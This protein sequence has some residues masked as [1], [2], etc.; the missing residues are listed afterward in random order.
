MILSGAQIA[1]SVRI[2]A[3]HFHVFFCHPFFFFFNCFG[4]VLC[5]LFLLFCFVVVVRGFFYFL[6]LCIIEAVNRC[7]Q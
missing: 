2:L 6:Y 5:V 1:D 4:L 7:Q 3:Q